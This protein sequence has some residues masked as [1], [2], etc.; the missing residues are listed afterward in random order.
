MN[1]N[2]YLEYALRDEQ[3]SQILMFLYTDR[4]YYR[5]HANPHSHFRWT[6]A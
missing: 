5:S 2:F 6:E 1:I 4:L 3:F